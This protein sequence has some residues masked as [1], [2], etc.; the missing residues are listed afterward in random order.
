MAGGLADRAK[1]AM[2]ASGR[3]L[4]MAKAGDALAAWIQNA[5]VTVE[6]LQRAM[7]RGDDVLAQALATAPREA[8]VVARTVAG[9][10]LASITP[11]DYPLV[12]QRL[13]DYPDCLPHAHLLYQDHYYHAHFVPAMDRARA[14]IAGA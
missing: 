8:L 9:P 14:W 5:G 2:A 7:D 1:A 4:A 6:G 13:G 3:A 11:A 12:L 10:V